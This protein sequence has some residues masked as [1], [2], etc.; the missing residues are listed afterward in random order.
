M[1]RKMDQKV[2]KKFKKKKK[3]TPD[4]D[5]SKP[6][7]QQPRE[8]KTRKSYTFEDK[9]QILD[10]YYEMN[11]GYK[12]GNFRALSQA[13]GVSKSMLH[14]W[15]NDSDKIFANAKEFAVCRMKKRTRQNKVYG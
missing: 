15:V 11:G 9:A 8:K 7:Q 5:A 1:D 2:D 10:R 6:W 14:K 4:M 3:S 12:K 13:L